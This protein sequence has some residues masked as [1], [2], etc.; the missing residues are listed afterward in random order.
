MTELN[1]FVYLIYKTDN[2]DPQIKYY[3]EILRK[4]YIKSHQV[5]WKEVFVS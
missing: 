5:K 1:T 4:Y 3:L 2:I